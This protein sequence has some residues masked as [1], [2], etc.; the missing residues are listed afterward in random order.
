[1]SG[2]SIK[3]YGAGIRQE[4]ELEQIVEKYQSMSDNDRSFDIKFWQN[5]GDKAIFEAAWEMLKDYCLIR[6]KDA[7][8]LR[9]QRTVETFRK[10]Q[11]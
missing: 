4:V 6:G 5:A 2:K 10:I 3:Y 11:S 8:E 7:A 9:I 1:M